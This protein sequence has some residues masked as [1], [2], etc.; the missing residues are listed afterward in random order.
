MLMLAV[1]LCFGV[2]EASEIMSLSQVKPGMKGKGR[3]VFQGTK[4]EE[5]DAEVLGILENVTPGRNIILARLAG[6]GLESSGIIAGMSGSPIYIDGKLIGAVAYGFAFSKEPICGITPIEEMLAIQNIP[7]IQAKP[8]GGVPTM[9]TSI[10]KDDFLEIW[11]EEMKTRSAAFGVASSGRSIVP[12]GVP[13]FFG[14]FTPAA[15]EQARGFF[16]PLGFQPIMGGSSSGGQLKGVKIPPAGE[17]PVETLREGDAVGVQLIGGDLNLSA[18]GTVT[19]VEGRRIL[20][21][22]HPFYNLGATDYGMTRADVITVLPSLESS[23]KMAVTGPVIG[24]FSQDRSTGVMGEIGKKPRY[25]PLNISLMNGPGAPKEFKLELA[26]DKFLTPALVNM[27][28]ASLLGS[29]QRN[30]G[31]LSLEFEGTVYTDSDEM[32]VKM[33][34]M[35]SG[36]YGSAAAGLSNMV[37]S[38]VYYLGNNEFRDTGIYRIDLNIRALE[39]ARF[40]A[41]EKVILDKYEVSPGEPIQI[42][43]V[44]RTYREEDRTEEATLVAPPLP[45]GTEFQIVVG[46]AATMAQ[47]ERAQYQSVDFLPRSYSQLV[48]VLGNLRKN[49]R[50]Y[51]KVVAPKPGLFMKG[52]EM[53]NLPPTLKAMF[54]SSR[55]SSA[56]PIELTRSTLGEYQL[57][58]P[59]V[60]RGGAVVQVKIKE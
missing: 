7:V 46:D 8:A 33:D 10:G 15:F 60:F 32:N 26:N 43:V 16:T 23:S 54:M 20:A 50:I 34:D 37:A 51:F 31:N 59:Y 4:I 52:E 35:F 6:H 27:A 14:G 57:Q 55:A 18:I 5:F 41:L 38:V 45:A 1:I 11:N 39:E 58:V 40:C 21:F 49:N 48:R 36:N 47:T 22:G 12:L 25:V 42:K 44:Y 9:R 28:L 53:P 3:S 13:L 2:S 56:S 17:L 24:S 30:Y 29:E 19:Y